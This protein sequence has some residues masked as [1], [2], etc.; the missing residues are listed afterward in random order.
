MEDKNEKNAQDHRDGANV[1]V[2]TQVWVLA[3]LS[4]PSL[5]S[6]IGAILNRLPI[7]R[8]ALPRVSLAYRAMP[9]SSVPSIT[10]DIDALTLWDYSLRPFGR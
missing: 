2:A 7:V 3:T 9:L 6:E 8:Y 4:Y 1:A 5:T 10:G